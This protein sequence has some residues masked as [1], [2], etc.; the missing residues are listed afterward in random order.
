MTLITQGSSASYT[1]TATQNITFTCDPGEAVSFVV[2]RSGAVVAGSRA[3]A[4]ETVGPY[5]TG[6]V[7]NMTAQRGDVDY[8]VSAWVDTQLYGL[9]ATDKTAVQALV[10]GAGRYRLN[11]PQ[12]AM[13]SPPTVATSTAGTTVSGG[14]QF[15]IWSSDSASFP[16]INASALTF[17]APAMGAQVLT[18]VT[19]NASGSARQNQTYR[20]V[21]EFDGTDIEFE[22]QSAGGTYWIKVNDE[23]I[24]PVGTTLASDAIVR[25][26]KV[27][28]A[29]RTACRIE[30]I[31]TTLALRSVYVNATAGLFP[32]A[33]RGPRCIMMQDS[34]GASS[35]CV[36]RVVADMLG[37]D[38]VWSSSVG[39]TGLIATNAGAAQNFGQRLAA[40]V[41]AYSPRVLWVVG[42]VNDDSLDAATVA[43]ALLDL[44]NR[45]VASNPTGI[46]VWSDN[47][48]N[49]PSSWIITKNLKRNACKAALS[50]LQN[51]Y[52]VDILE[53]P[54]YTRD[55]NPSG[56]LRNA[57]AVNNTTLALYGQQTIGGWPQAG[58]VI[59]I[60]DEYLEVKS[61]AFTGSDAGRYYFTVQIDGAVKQAHLAGATWAEV[62]ASYITGSGSAGTPSGF[63]SSD[64]Y[65]I[66]SVDI[67]PTVSGVVAMGK[68][69][70]SAAS[71]ILPQV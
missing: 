48:S 57:A 63:G 35:G 33:V 70:A 64:V 51:T 21:M 49:G 56:V 36:Q 38:D 20:Y 45:F 18:P 4:G 19:T 50:G 52:V 11:A 37:W 9:T 47:A 17:A 8:T 23:Y 28:F 40:D 66:S 31:S 34:F 69:L 22:N 16:F 59:K 42:S 26:I 54:I 60:D 6:D 32:G 3:T 67:H 55:A 25:N 2:T 39:G 62:G 53:A 71:R 44:R 24:D 65:R 30:W 7:I 46:F 15:P 29:A 13:A 68:A 12:K 5:L 41:L 43:A 61:G 1:L 58:S 10:S 14:R 27:T